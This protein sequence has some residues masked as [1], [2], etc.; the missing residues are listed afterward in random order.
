MI[1]GKPLGNNVRIEIVNSGFTAMQQVDEREARTEKA[2]V[3]EVGKEVKS[4][5]PKD[6]I[7]FKAYNIDEIEIDNEKYVII[8]EEDIKYVFTSKKASFSR[9]QAEEALKLI[10]I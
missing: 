9:E 3:L 1:K 6:T 7:L 4:V 8:P 10:K 2:T 5:K